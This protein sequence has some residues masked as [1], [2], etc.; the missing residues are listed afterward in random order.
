MKRSFTMRLLSLA[1][2][3]VI[4]CAVWGGTVSFADSA[5]STDFGTLVSDTAVLENENLRFE[6]K[7]SGRFCLTDLSNGN[8]WI[9]NPADET[10]DKVAFGVNKDKVMSQVLVTYSGTGVVSETATFAGLAATDDSYTE[11][12]QNGNTV[13]CVYYFK[14]LGFVIPVEYTVEGNR[15]YTTVCT[16][17][18]QETEKY[19]LIDF[20]LNPFFGAGTTE[21][22][23][24]IMLPDGS[25]ATINFNN[26]KTA[27]NRLVLDVLYGDLS[28]VSED[29]APKVQPVLIPA[30][31]ISKSL[32]DSTA[33]MLCVA[34]SG[35]Y[36]G[37]ITT[38]V[39]GRETGSNYAYFTFLFREYSTETMLDR[40]YAAKTRLVVAQNTQKVEKFTLCYSISGG[41]ENGLAAIAKSC[42][43]LIFGDAAECSK[44]E[45]PMFLDI[46]MGVRVKKNF[47]G[48]PYKTLQALTTLEETKG[49][50]S[51]FSD[52]G[53]NKLEIR[54]QGISADGFMSGK[55]DSKLSL[56]RKI[57]SLKEFEELQKTEGTSIYPKVELINYTRSGN[58]VSKFFDSSLDLLLDTIIVPRYL[59]AAA[60]ADEEA[61]TGRLI[62]PAKIEEVKNKLQKNL[63][64][65]EIE[66]ISPV[67]LAQGAYCDYSKKRLSGF[68]QTADTMLDAVKSLSEEQKLLL[69]AP[70]YGAWNYADGIIYLPD[71]SSHYNICDG[72]VPFLQMV[73]SGIVPYSSSAINFSGD[74]DLAVLNAIRYGSAP[75][76]MLTAAEYSEM[77][78]N[79][80]RDLFAANFDN[81]FEA[82]VT[83]YNSVSEALGEVYG[84]CFT[85]FVEPVEDFTVSKYSN[86]VTVLVNSSEKD[87]VW[88]GVTVPAY[89]YLTLEKGEQ[90]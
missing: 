13:T 15:L 78:D 62:A 27:E 49:I 45:L 63:K 34:T 71:D 1:V 47:L 57:G 50:I 81:C 21:E 75:A 53:I 82:A 37:K 7:S 83:A 48:I 36:G 60:V 51:D 16:E 8:R 20:T 70:V 59:L 61:P 5:N 38:N 19:R 41:S 52:K 77:N 10:E 23:G 84:L 6:I 55:I 9:S 54:M 58:G 87:I 17:K 44:S 32:S 85:D 46:I 14:S 31:G 12:Y 90:Q 11:L 76:F 28:K 26:G 35:A 56:N 72:T 39:S 30:F 33:N 67:T 24:Y 3:I 74:T 79:D 68:A 66:G 89:S 4:L 29:R 18:V 69:E 86:G 64:K 43:E 2:A 88:Q 40:T 80:A 25:G 42:R 73:M 65:K 22:D